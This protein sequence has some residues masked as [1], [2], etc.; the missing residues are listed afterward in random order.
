MHNFAGDEINNNTFW[1]ISAT[2]FEG[3]FSQGCNYGI[4]HSVGLLF[5]SI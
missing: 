4:K 5:V 3:G 2:T 1:L